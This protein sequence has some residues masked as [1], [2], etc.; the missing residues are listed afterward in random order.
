MLENGIDHMGLMEVNLDTMCGSVPKLLNNVSRKIFNHS[1]QNSA[2]S[3][4]L[5]KE[6]YKPGG[7]LD[8]TQGILTGCIIEKGAD[9]YERW[10]CK[11]T[12]KQGITTYHQQVALLR[13][14]FVTDLTKRLEEG[15]KK[16]EL[17]II[18]GDFN[19]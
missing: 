14:A 5:V 8:M 10:P 4:I 12:K 1:Q 6:Y 16:R 3:S 18:G 7:T 9:T 11:V 19:E 2:S 13:E 15:G 17:F